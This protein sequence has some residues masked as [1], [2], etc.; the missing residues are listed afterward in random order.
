MN[1]SINGR[2]EGG[3]CNLM[4]KNSELND[5]GKLVKYWAYKFAPAQFSV[6]IIVLVLEIKFIPIIR[7]ASFNC[8]V[9]TQCA[10]W[11]C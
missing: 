11:H 9:T 5:N 1:G 4:N 8:A 3:Y 7:A 10:T 6:K 2:G